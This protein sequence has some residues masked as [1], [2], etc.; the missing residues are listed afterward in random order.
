MKCKIYN[1]LLLLFINF[2]LLINFDNN[3]IFFK[4]IK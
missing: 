3:F 1:I 2:G 4:I